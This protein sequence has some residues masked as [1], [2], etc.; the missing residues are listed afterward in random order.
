MT[1]N[2]AILTYNG[3]AYFGFSGCTYA[4]PDLRRLEAVLMLNFMELRDA[5]GGK[6][7]GK[8]KEEKNKK[9]TVRAKA[10]VASTPPALA[11]KSV[12]STVPV[13]PLASVE[14]AIAPTTPVEENKVW[15]QLIA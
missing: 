14:S 8:K 5:V 12:G 2:C 13:P 1:L 6:P 11:P 15:T 4:A 9:K 3:T 7:S 10:K